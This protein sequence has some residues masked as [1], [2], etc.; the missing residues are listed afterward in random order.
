MNPW[1]GAFVPAACAGV[2]MAAGADAAASTSAVATE[3]F[4]KPF[5]VVSFVVEI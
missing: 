5:T 4:R 2:A 3:N 1:G